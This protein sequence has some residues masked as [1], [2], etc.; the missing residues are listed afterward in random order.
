MSEQT[1]SAGYAFAVYMAINLAF[2]HNES[3]YYE[4]MADGLR[5][6]AKAATVEQWNVDSQRIKEAR[7]AAKQPVAA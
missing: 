5:V 7:E 1:R 6:L 3:R 4:G 2:D